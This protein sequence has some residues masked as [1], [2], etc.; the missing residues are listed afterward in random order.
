MK[1][2]AF[3]LGEPLWKDTKH[4]LLIKKNLNLLLPIRFPGTVKIPV[5]TG[6]PT[7]VLFY[8]ISIKSF[9]NDRNHYVQHRENPNAKLIWKSY[10]CIWQG[11][12]S[13]HLNKSKYYFQE[14]VIFKSQI[15]Y[16]TIK[17]NKL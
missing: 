15:K 14:I 6:L 1:Q 7:K 16:L 9:T 11:Q 5:L 12:Y 3:A 4:L 10:S 13:K 17:I 8:I 2:D